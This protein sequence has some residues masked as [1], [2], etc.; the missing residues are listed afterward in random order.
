MSSIPLQPESF[1]V[2]KQ[3]YQLK[4][5]DGTPIDHSIKDTFRRV[6]KALAAVEA[7]NELRE[8]WEAQFYQAMCDGA[9]PAGRILSNAGAGDYKKETSLINCC[10]SNLIHDSINGIMTGLHEAALSLKVGN[11]IGYDFSTLRPKGGFIAGAG[12]R[13]S[14]A[15]SFM[16]I[17]DKMCFSI[18]SAGGRRGAQMAAM[19]VS[20][21]DILE[22]ITA[23]REEGRFRQFNCSVLITESF[24]NAVAHHEVWPLAFPMTQHEITMTGVDLDDQTQVIWQEWP[25]HDNYLVKDSKVACRIYKIVKAKDLWTT[26]LRSTYEFSEPG[27]MFIDHINR[28]NNNAWCEDIRT[29]N[30]CFTGDTLVC[31]SH[32]LIPFKTLAEKGRSV[33]VL[34]EVDGMLTYH[35]MSHPRLT[36]KNSKLVKVTFITGDA[37]R[38]TPNHNFYLKD[39]TAIEAKD[40]REGVRVKCFENQYVCM[41]FIESVEPLSD[42]EDVYCG[43]VEGIGKFFVSLRDRNN[44][45]L[46]SNCGEVPLPPYGSCLL[47]SINLT[48]FVVNPFADNA[49]FDWPKYERTIAVFTR[50]LDNV[51]E[52]SGLILEGQRKEIANKRRHGMGYFGLGS[53]MTLL[54]MRYGSPASLQFT[55]KVTKTLALIG[56]KQALELSK[57]KG[58]APILDGFTRLTTELKQKYPEIS[59]KQW[60]EWVGDTDWISNKILHARCSPYMQRIGTIDP[61][62][63]EELCVHGARFTHHTAIAPT[64]T[65]ALSVGNNASNGIEPSFSHSYKRNVIKEGKKTKEQVDVYAYEYLARLECNPPVSAFEEYFVTANDL[66]PQEHIDVQSEAQYWVDQSISKTVNVPFDMSFYDFQDVYQYAYEKGLK[67]VATFRFNPAVFQGVLV[68]ESDLDK[69]TYRFVLDTG[70]VIDAKGNEQIDYDGEIHTAANLYDA[71]NEGYYGKH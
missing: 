20:H 35:T 62:L 16:D 33:R 47:G 7:T 10:V 13:T 52:I 44:G 45:V 12:A 37:I 68:N 50:M 36:Q 14:G 38:C 59:E 4:D 65:L 64:G 39:G 60:T 43:T 6:A 9:I 67:G 17:Y 3:K 51:V 11:G 58:P 55:R 28:M 71:I 69:T 30:P 22:F 63:I 57:E 70:E 41:R 54:K 19:T 26:I 8:R 21:P 31:T 66:T 24:M 15:L 25:I 46:V 29:S 2:W 27:I 61:H 18:A 34:T 49:Y 32:G 56:W 1:A 5:H 53:A 42:V 23:K 48:Q 40:L